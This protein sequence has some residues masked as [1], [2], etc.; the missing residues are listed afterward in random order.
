[1]PLSVVP[2][3]RVAVD[4]VGPL[5][6]SSER[7]H[8]FILVVVDF[9]TRYPEAVPLRH[10]DTTT[11]A[12]ALWSIWTR[13]GVPERILTDRG[14]QFTSEQM[15]EVNRLLSIHG[16]TTTP[17]HAQCNGAVERFNGTL[18]TMIRRLCSDQPREWD[19]FLSTLL[20]AYRE[21]PYASSGFSP[22]ELLYG[23]TVRGPLQ[24]LRQLWLDEEEKRETITTAQYVVDLR[25][26]I[27]DACE[28]AQ[29]NLDV[30]AFRQRQINDRSAASRSFAAGD[31]VLLLRPKK[32]NKLEL[33][34][35][36][37]YEDLERVGACAYRIQMGRKL[38]LFHANLLREYVDRQSEEI[39]VVVTEA[40]DM[41]E[42]E[43]TSSIP[44]VP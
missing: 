16:H 26:R 42:V 41:Q 11:V 13:V 20:F 3:Q 7:G 25:N 33:T 28:R 37:P 5:I 38:K 44:V 30:E 36:G 32:E 8:R 18:K 24:I 2:F 9:A 1:M 19:R 43:E 23:R 22:F 21:V 4:L 34:W 31:K 35:Q 12:E 14:S 40:G 17:Y 6:P 15:R 39:L 27:A 29:E 10:I